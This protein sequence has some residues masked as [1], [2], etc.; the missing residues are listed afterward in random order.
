M[1]KSW[2]NWHLNEGA[3]GEVT[4]EETKPQEDETKHSFQKKKWQYAC[5]LFGINSLKEGAM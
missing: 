5:R 2:I 4:T 3:V 1:M